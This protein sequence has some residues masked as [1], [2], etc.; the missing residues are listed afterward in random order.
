MKKSLFFGLLPLW[1]A[2]IAVVIG[3]FFSSSVEYWNTAPWL[4]M[5][6][7]PLCLLTILLEKNK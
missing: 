2:I 4:I 5:V 1:L 6:S 7:I 3:S